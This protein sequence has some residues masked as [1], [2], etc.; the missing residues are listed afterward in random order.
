MR[1][2]DVANERSEQGTLRDVIRQQ[3]G[4]RSSSW[5]NHH[6]TVALPGRPAAKMILTRAS[7]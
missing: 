4:G 1:G 6:Q 2:A 3:H 5:R 7:V